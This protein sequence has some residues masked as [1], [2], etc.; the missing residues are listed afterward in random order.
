MVQLIATSQDGTNQVQ[1][2]TP[3]VPIQLNFQFQDLAKPFA[4]RSP[5]SFNFKL[6]ATRENLKF[7]SFY[8]DYN[9]SL[10][11]FKATKRTNVDVYDNGILVMSGIMQLLN[12]TEE[13]YTVVVFEELA[14]LFET[15][16]DLSWEQLFITEAGTVDTD[17]DHFLTWDNIIASW[18]LTD[19]TTGNVGGGVIVY[20]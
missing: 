8:Y 12:A 13:E 10:G 6:P 17:L 16:K 1:L 5:Y 11:T 14:K 19:I 18:S 7:F 15:I 4:N 20:P 2:D 9:V 3:K